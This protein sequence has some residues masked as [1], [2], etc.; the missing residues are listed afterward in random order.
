VERN[1]FYWDAKTVKLNE[2]HYYPVTNI[3]TEDIMFRAG[4]LHLTYDVPAQKCPSY[5]KD[6]PNMKTD[7]Y[8]GQYFYRIN[9]NHPILKDV[10][11][12]KALS[13]SI[14]RQKIVDRVTQCGE[15]AAISITPPGANGYMPETTL[16]FNPE[17]AKMLLIEA[18]YEDGSELEGLEILFN[19][20]ENHRKI[21]LAVQ[22]MWQQNLGVSVELV[23]QDWKVYLAREM[24]GD[25]TIS[26]AGWIGD[27]EDPNTFLDL[28]RP[29]RGNN[30][31][32]WSNA[33]YDN[34]V[35]QANKTMDQKERYILLNKAEKIIM[36]ELP[37]LPVYSYVKDYQ[38][39]SDVKGFY[40]NYLDHHHPKYIYLERD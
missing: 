1:P 17:K 21:A 2:I 37:I 34:Y 3:M 29:N 23:N 20:N 10:R 9:T 27:Y 13:L 4:Q 5:I 28:F 22:Q 26:R 19:T 31:T 36:N 14:D 40:P 33:E 12:R 38:I 6:N 11:V 30:K 18:G 24:I 16:E 32:G 35:E 15:S 39:S 8:M 7:P 25:F